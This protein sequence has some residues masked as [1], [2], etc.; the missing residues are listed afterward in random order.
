MDSVTILY[1]LGVSYPRRSELVEKKQPLRLI[2]LLLFETNETFYFIAIKK[3]KAMGPETKRV[4]TSLCDRWIF[5]NLI[6][7]LVSSSFVGAC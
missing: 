2:Y 7:T 1:Q 3:Y 5:S 6:E 4:A